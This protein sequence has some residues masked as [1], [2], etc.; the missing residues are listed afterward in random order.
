MSL[1]IHVTAECKCLNCG[2]RLKLASSITTD[3]RPDP[4]DATVCLDCGHVMVFADDLS[5]R[6]PTDAEVIEL[7]GDADLLA[8]QEMLA[9]LRKEHPP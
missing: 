2:K 5:V 9:A 3:A 8:T 4:G 7:A 1:E 6:E